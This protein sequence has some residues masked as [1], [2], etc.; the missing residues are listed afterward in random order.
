[1]LAVL[2]SWTKNDTPNWLLIDNLITWYAKRFFNVFPA[3][4]TVR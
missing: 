3:L 2:I 1:M 4:F